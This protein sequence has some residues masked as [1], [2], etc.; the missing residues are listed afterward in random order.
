MLGKCIRS[1]GVALY[2]L[3]I[4]SVLVLSTLIKAILQQ[5]VHRLETIVLILK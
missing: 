5:Y 2:N 3:A 4:A 1:L